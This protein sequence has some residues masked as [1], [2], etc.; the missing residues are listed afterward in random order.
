MARYAIRARRGG[1]FGVYDL[2][3]KWFVETGL[4]TRGEAE[5]AIALREEGDA[6]PKPVKVDSRTC[7]GI[8]YYATE[9]DAERVGAYIAKRGDTYN[10][11]WYHGMPCGRDASWDYT[12]KETNQKLY[13]VTTA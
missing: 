7:F 3:N 9:E 10:G 11:G 13:A 1:T 12:N 8:S 4:T 2:V 5:Q 6:L